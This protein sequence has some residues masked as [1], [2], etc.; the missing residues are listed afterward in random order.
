MSDSFSG[1]G[2]VVGLKAVIIRAELRVLHEALSSA[3]LPIPYWAFAGTAL[4]VVRDGGLIVHDADAD[5]KVPAKYFRWG[6]G[7]D[8]H[9][10]PS[11]GQVYQAL[12]R[13]VDAFYPGLFAVVRTGPDDWK[14]FASRLHR[15]PH[16]SQDDSFLAN[17]DP[18]Y[19]AKSL[20]WDIPQKIR[21]FARA[22]RGA[23][24]GT[25]NDV[26]SIVETGLCWD[27]PVPV[28]SLHVSISH[29]L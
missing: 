12:A 2:R 6:P 4:G 19:T 25:H 29:L 5:V 15:L 14:R 21:L 20:E 27:A 11:G 13:H 28:V 10:R 23:C 8:L 7:G 18:W 9:T 3:A 26:P 22:Q 1:Q 16:S 24:A 17:K